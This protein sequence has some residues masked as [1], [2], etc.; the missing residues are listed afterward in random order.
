MN[1]ALAKR[2]V[3]LLI[4]V[5][6]LLEKQANSSYVLDLLSEIVHYDDADCDGDCLLNDIKDHLETIEWTKKNTPESMKKQPEKLLIRATDEVQFL[7]KIVQDPNYPGINIDIVDNEE[8]Y[9]NAGVLLEY[10]KENN[11]YVAKIWSDVDLEEPES[12]DI[13]LISDEPKSKN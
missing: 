12:V 9:L 8:I 3:E 4:A 13:K 7:A 10:C 5:K 11:R 2:S 1:E 6:E